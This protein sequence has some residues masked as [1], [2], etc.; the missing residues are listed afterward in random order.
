MLCL[1]IS[2]KI[3]RKGNIILSSR[4]YRALSQKTEFGSNKEEPPLKGFKLQRQVTTKERNYTHSDWDKHRSCW[5]HIRHMKL[6]P[7]AATL[8]RLSFPDLFLV[9]ATSTSLTL[10]NTKIIYTQEI[11]INPLPF[12]VCSL[13]LGLLVTFRTNASYDRYNEARL[14]WGDII[15]A[16]RD[17]VRQSL[18]IEMSKEHHRLYKLIKAFPVVMNFQL[19]STG[20][21]ESDIHNQLT[22][23]LSPV[24]LAEK[25]NVS[26]TAHKES[27]DDLTRILNAVC[28]GQGSINPNLVCE[29]DKQVKRLNTC[30]G[31]CDRI[32]MTPIPT[33]YTRHTSVFLTVWC[34]MLPLALWP[35]VGSAT[36]PVSLF[37][38]FGIYGIEDIGVQ[39]E[40]PFQVL[41]LRNYANA[42]QVSTDAISESFVRK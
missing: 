4:L 41:P 10:W 3:R 39:I 6:L 25:N 13:A 24:F 1:S 12:T 26:R 2:N 8:Q 34:N 30:I 29:M 33:C 9:G 18:I 21:S 17:L 20:L 27:L 11:S 7:W 36:V 23:E 32:R 14:I 35:L 37:I 40:E 19:T 5:R 42:V 38:A 16:S 28:V 15:N 22:E 31:A